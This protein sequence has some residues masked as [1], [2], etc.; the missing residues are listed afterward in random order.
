[1][2]FSTAHSESLYHSLSILDLGIFFVILAITLFA[3]FYGNMRRNKG[4]DSFFDYLIMG[5]SLTLPMFVA[6]L[7]AT[8]Y[9][10]IFGVTEIAYEKGIYNF[11]TQGVFWYVAY[12]IFAFFIVHKIKEADVFSMPEFCEKLFGK[13]ARLVAAVFN[14]VDLIPISYMIGVGLFLSIL[15]GTSL[16]FGIVIGCFFVCIY[17]SIGGFR[18]VVYSDIV[19]FGVMCI[20]VFLVV[21][22]S[23][24]QFGGLSYLRASLPETHFSLDG[25]YLEMFSWG[26]IALS[27]LVDP[28]FHQRC[29]AAKDTATAK[30]GILIAIV[31]W[32]MFDLCTTFGAMYAR[33]AMQ[34]APAQGAYLKYAIA[35]L[36]DGFR[37]FFL[38]G[39][40]A[41]ILS[42]LDSGLF[43]ASQTLSY[44]ML[45][46]RKKGFFVVFNIFI[47]GAFA[48]G[49]ALVF[50]GSIKMV[51]KTLGAYNAGC[52]LF[53]V[54]YGIFRP[55][56]ERE[57]LSGVILG[58]IAVSGWRL[59]QDIN[60]WGYIDALYVG[61]LGSSSGM[62]LAKVF[63]KGPVDK[64]N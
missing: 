6:T 46:L 48:V 51:W 38:A 23:Y 21:W 12:L 36:P 63:I 34:D 7:V 19:Q 62:L 14:F 53:P 1:M 37:G 10:A 4:G 11:V 20:S 40:L 43:G 28:R 5:R 30:F 44:D 15:F 50:D 41:T 2:Y 9:G 17:S 8:W 32:I 26:F 33:A 39:I 45:G 13:K 18:S 29:I 24:W 57:F 60:P 59:S 61:L 25:D 49:L 22:F 64:G 58:V 31:I 56:K 16:T 55:L 52:L 35:T 27:T 47:I 42:T 3:I 54:V